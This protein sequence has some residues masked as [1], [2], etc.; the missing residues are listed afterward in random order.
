MFVGSLTLTWLISTF[1]DLNFLGDNIFKLVFLIDLKSKKKYHKTEPIL[2]SS[3]K[4]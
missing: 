3:N 2:A 4:E 1:H